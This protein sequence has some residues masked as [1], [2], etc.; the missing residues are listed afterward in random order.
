MEPKRKK[1][2]LELGKSRESVDENGMGV[3]SLSGPVETAFQKDEGVGMET[4]TPDL[5]G[6]EAQDVSDVA[7]L[8]EELMKARMEAKEYLDLAKRTRAELINFRNR[9]EKENREFRKLAIESLILELIPVI[10]SLEGAISAFKDADDGEN[11]LLQGVRKIYA[12]L[13]AVL[14]NHGV[15]IYGQVGD[16][17]NANLHEPL[18]S[19]SSREV[20]EDTICGVYQKGVRIGDKVVKPAR[21]AVKTPLVLQTES[22]AQAREE[23]GGEE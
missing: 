15:E 23:N 22:E 6:T 7:T 14:E 12:Q 20:T 9:V 19:E 1:D 16:K 21:V 5:V 3:T 17:F 8:T 11:P 18:R 10:D 13:H 4:E 2:N